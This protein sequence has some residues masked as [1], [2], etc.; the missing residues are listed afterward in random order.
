L[1]QATQERQQGLSLRERE[2]EGSLMRRLRLASAR[3]GLYGRWMVELTA[4]GRHARWA[5]TRPLVSLL[6]LPDTI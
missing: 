5:R 3:T 2:A 1:A 6:R 4:A